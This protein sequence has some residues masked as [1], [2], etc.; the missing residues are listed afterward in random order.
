M[1]D[2]GSASIVVERD[3]KQK[4]GSSSLNRYNAIAKR[5]SGF[6]LISGIGWC[7]DFLTMATLTQSGLPVFWAN[8]IGSIWLR[9]IRER[10]NHGAVV[11]TDH[12]VL[13]NLIGQH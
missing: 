6:A 1:K 4:S 2:A 8:F 12:N 3:D 7:L 13:P 5:F 9:I 10:A 11:V